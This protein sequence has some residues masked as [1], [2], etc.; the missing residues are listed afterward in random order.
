MYRHVVLVLLLLAACSSSSGEDVSLVVDYSFVELEAALGDAVSRQDVAAV[1]AVVG[2]PSEEGARTD[3]LRAFFVGLDSFSL[4]AGEA[5][6]AF[7]SLVRQERRGVDMHLN[8]TESG[9]RFLY[10]ASP[11]EHVALYESVRIQ[12]GSLTGTATVPFVKQESDWFVSSRLDSLVLT[13]SSSLV[14]VLVNSSH[15]RMGVRD[16]QG[17]FYHLPGFG[18]ELVLSDGEE[19]LCSSSVVL[20]EVEDALP[21]GD[22]HVGY[23]HSADCLLEGFAGAYFVADF[24]LFSNESALQGRFFVPSS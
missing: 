22:V 23:W 9:I 2:A 6:A 1:H 21:S 17:R 14:S 16:A 10:A 8:T 3:A 19:V 4:Q 5:S 15:V 12:A 13:N 18:H 11:D 24:L 7:D 20:E